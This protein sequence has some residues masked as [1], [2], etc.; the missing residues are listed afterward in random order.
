MDKPEKVVKR[1]GPRG[2]KELVI[3]SCRVPA[4]VWREFRDAVKLRGLSMNAALVR[5]VSGYASSCGGPAAAPAGAVELLALPAGSGAPA[6]STAAADAGAVLQA[7]ASGRR[8]D[9]LLDAGLIRALV[10]NPDAIGQLDAKT[11]AQLAV[12]RAP[13]AKAV[14]EGLNE[15][16]LSLMRVLEGVPSCD[17]EALHGELRLA[18]QAVELYR[19]E[20][21]AAHEREMALRARLPEEQR[22][23]FREACFG[24]QRAVW[25]FVL[26][27]TLRGFE[28]FGAKKGG[29]RERAVGTGENDGVFELPRFGWE[30]LRED[31]KGLAELA[32]NGIGPFATELARQRAE[33]VKKA[34]AER[35]AARIEAARPAKEAEHIAEWKS[36]GCPQQKFAPDVPRQFVGIDTTVMFDGAEELE[37]EDAFLRSLEAKAA[38]GP[39]TDEELESI[40]DED[41]T[42]GN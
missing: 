1:R 30:P 6:E 16:Y 22:K 20:L 5:L 35:R 4:G 29:P 14:D 12:S 25:E 9:D 13:K 19:T 41:D 26:N 10:E 40:D 32:R 34:K 31:E 38:G 27:G 7:S 18:R 3:M 42:T 39:L 28:F 21:K 33:A 15:Q 23:A 2:A 24:W 37:E 11:L 8:L 17:A 36:R